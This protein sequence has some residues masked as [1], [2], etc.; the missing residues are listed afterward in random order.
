MPRRR[1][2]SMDAPVLISGGGIGGLILALALKKH[3][4]LAGGEIEVYEQAPGFGDNVGG[5][6]G[7]YA[8][9]LR[10]VRDISPELL[11][12]IRAAGYD[13]IFRRWFRHDGTEVA[14]ARESELASDPDLQSIGI[15]RWKLQKVLFD[16]GLVNGV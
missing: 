8:N 2:T 14:C 16:I 15:R 13:Y 7:L 1:K 12:S 5:A 6:M 11:A 3:C 4:G 10:V 9:G